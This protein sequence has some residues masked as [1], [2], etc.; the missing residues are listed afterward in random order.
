MELV[1][2]MLVAADR[3]DVEGLRNDCIPRLMT[4][5]ATDTVAH[6]LTLAHLHKMPDLK[7]VCLR[8]ASQHAVAVT[9]SEGWAHLMVGA[10]Q[11]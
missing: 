11:A 3:Y 6:T 8:F 1:Q 5:L 4:T 7:D 10:L 9:D 2:H